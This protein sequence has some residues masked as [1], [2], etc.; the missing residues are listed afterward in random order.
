MIR[1]LLLRHAKSSW[2]DPDLKDFDRPLND[3]GREAAQ[4]MAAF[5]GFEGLLPA[6]ILCS[7]AQRTRETL[8][9]LLLHFP[10]DADIC[11]SRRL[12]EA[13]APGYLE[14]IRDYGATATTL[15]VIGHNPAME[16]VATI[17]APIGDAPALAAMHEKFPTCGLA[18]I[19][20]EAPRFS[21]VDPGGGLLSAF[22]TPQ[23]VQG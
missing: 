18:V 3:R 17:L 23:S 6:R 12:Y 11:L 19:D 8:A 21:E 15:M 5:M 14:A 2:D 9:H 10:E 13:D 20:F 16:D 4:L 7:S 22:H 1:L